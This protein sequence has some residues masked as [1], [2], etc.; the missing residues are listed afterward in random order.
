MLRVWNEQLWYNKID[1][2]YI[3]YNCFSDFDS[4]R[5]VWEDVQEQEFYVQPSLEVLQQEEDIS[6]S[7]F[8]V[9]LFYFL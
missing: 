1:N 9:Y 2:T 8:W 7:L 6:V 5:E 3:L 4:V